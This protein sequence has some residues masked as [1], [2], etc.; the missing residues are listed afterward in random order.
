MYVTK[1]VANRNNKIID[2]QAQT[3]QCCNQDMAF[4]LCSFCN[5]LICPT[6]IEDNET[7]LIC[8]NDDNI[9]EIL[10][11]YEKSI[12]TGKTFLVKIKNGKK[13][14]IVK[15]ILGCFYI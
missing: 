13:H 10:Q 1:S 7:C 4:M 11:S 15:N 3:C 6:C 14:I 5:R 12:K 2:I 8:Y 9:T